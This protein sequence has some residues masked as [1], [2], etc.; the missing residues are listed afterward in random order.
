MLFQC[1][2]IVKGLPLSLRLFLLEKKPVIVN[3][4][5]SEC[6]Q[7]HSVYIYGVQGGA[8]YEEVHDLWQRVT[9]AEQA[10]SE[11]ATELHTHKDAARHATLELKV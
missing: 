10:A 9:K 8:C 11:A 1:T 3:V 5:P 6:T 2:L 7:A 4:T